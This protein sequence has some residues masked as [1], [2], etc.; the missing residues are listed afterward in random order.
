MNQIVSTRNTYTC[1]YSVKEYYCYEE[2]SGNSSNCSIESLA[3]ADNP[4]APNDDHLFNDDRNLSSLLYLE[5]LY[6]IQSNYFSHVQTEIK[7]WM[8]KMLANWMQEV[9]KNQN[10]EAD[11]F[12]TAM[13]IL[14]RFL[15]LQPVSKRHLQL[16][17][18]VCMF[19]AAKLRSSTKLNAETLVIYTANSVTI[20]QLL[21]WEQLVLTKLKW[22]INC[23]TA[24]DYVPILLSRL[25]IIEHNNIKSIRGYMEKLITMCSTDFKF[26]MVPNS[27]IA[28]GCLFLTIKHLNTLDINQSEAIL[29]ELNSAINCAIDT[30]I[31]CQCIEQIEQLIQS[32]LNN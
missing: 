10:Q 21:D 25:N 26:S 1:T 20:E 8:R 6:R 23:V 4:K 19:I 22:D 17:G 3:S 12:V 16:L 18:T 29:M 14:D 9:C 5:D 27:I 28:T 11:V 31:L 2:D 24:C 13:N 15:S 7:T 32:D 30:E